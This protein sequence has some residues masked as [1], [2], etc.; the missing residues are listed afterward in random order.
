[1]SG[2]QTIGSNRNIVS[3]HSP[4]TIYPLADVTADTVGDASWNMPDVRC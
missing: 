4:I 1:M 2:E 3:V